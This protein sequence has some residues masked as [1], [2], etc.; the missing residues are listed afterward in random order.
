MHGI[1]KCKSFTVR[2]LPKSTCYE[3]I[4]EELFLNWNLHLN[5][6]HWH[7]TSLF[8]KFYAD[9]MLY[10]FLVQ[11]NKQ[12]WKRNFLQEQRSF[13]IVLLGRVIKKPPANYKNVRIYR[14][15]MYIDI[16]KKMIWYI[17]W[18]QRNFLILPLSW[19]IEAQHMYEYVN[20]GWLHHK[21]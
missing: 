9:N 20:I 7:I 10:Y 15:C 6:R 8:Y 14:N 5:A 16:K 12:I 3:I 4:D 19:T 2:F 11:T 17:Y 18:I 21:W 1:S 13:L